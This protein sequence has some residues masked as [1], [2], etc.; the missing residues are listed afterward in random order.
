M[1][2][3][4]VQAYTGVTITLTTHD[5]RYNLLTLLRLV[6]ADVPPT[7]RELNIQFDPVQ[8]GAAGSLLIG[9]GQCSDVAMGGQRCSLILLPGQSNHYGAGADVRQVYI[10]NIFLVSDTMDGMLVNVEVQN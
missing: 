1:S 8:A 5:T 4:S 10:N 2:V 7:C 6:S 9:D 3:E